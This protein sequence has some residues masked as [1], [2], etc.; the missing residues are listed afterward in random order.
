MSA[1]PVPIAELWSTE[2][3]STLQEAELI[4]ASQQVDLD[5]MTVEDSY[6]G[7]CMEGAA[8]LSIGFAI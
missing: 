6:D 3:T 8:R 2:N 5:S 4:P 1:Q 7:P